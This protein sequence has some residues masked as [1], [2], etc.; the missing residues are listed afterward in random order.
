M[1]TNHELQLHFIHS[2][3]HKLNCIETLSFIYLD[4]FADYKRLRG[5]VYFVDEL[6]LTPSGKIIRR[7]VREIAIEMYENEMEP[8]S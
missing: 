4:R 3:S 5:G 7:R 8:D 1:K 2:E 6:P